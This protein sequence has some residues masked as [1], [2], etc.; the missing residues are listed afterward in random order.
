MSTSIELMHLAIIVISLLLGVGSFN[1]QSLPCEDSRCKTG[2]CDSTGA[3]ICNFPHPSTILD[4][5]RPFLGGKFCDEE[6]TMCDGTNS[7]WCENGGICQEIVQGEDYLCKC[8]PGYTG[9]HCQHPGVPCGRTFCFHEAE[10]LTE[11]GVCQCAP[12]WRGSSDCSLPTH[13]TTDSSMDSTMSQLPHWGSS[14]GSTSWI[15]V[16]V[17]ISFSIGAVAGGAIYVKK[18]FGKK[19]TAPKFQQLSRMQSHMD[20]DEADAMV[21]EMSRNGSRQL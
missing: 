4:G 2:S 10:C 13:N 16:V 17:A 1:V 11:S 20:D 8:R 7:F 19:E 3:C 6:M 5:D 14:N 21:P 18:L 15:V 9:E 12:N